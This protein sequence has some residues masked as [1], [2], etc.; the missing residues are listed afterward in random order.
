MGILNYDTH[1]LLPDF[2][3]LQ[4]LHYCVEC[5][6]EGSKVIGTFAYDTEPYKRG[7]GHWAVGP[8]FSDLEEFYTWAKTKGFLYHT[9]GRG[10]VMVREFPG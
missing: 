4:E 10:Y 1:I 9:Y 2:S 8:V 3:S 6:D 5:T 7:L